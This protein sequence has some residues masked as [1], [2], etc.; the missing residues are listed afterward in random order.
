MRLAAVLTFAVVAA[1][2]KPTGSYS[3]ALV[4][5][6]TGKPVAGVKVLARSEPLSQIMECQVLDSTSTADGKIAFSPT[7]AETTYKLEVKDDT[8]SFEAPVTFDGT[9]VTPETSLTLW[10]KPAQA[11]LALLSAEGKLERLPTASAVTRRNFLGSEEQAA[12]PTTLPDSVARVEP[13]TWLV[14][15]PST[16]I[17]KIEIF[18]LIADASARKFGTNDEWVTLEPWSYIGIQFKT[19]REWTIVKAEVDASKVTDKSLSGAAVRYIEGS[20]LPAGRYAL[21]G[22][23]D[24]RVYIVDFGPAGG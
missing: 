4:D 2:K 12:W 14:L 5:G 1:C 6:M 16:V 15:T 10:R 9:A 21:L 3:A 7:C 22:K 23:A 13:G 24:P 11:G 17:D 20:A 18:P 8:L 19:D